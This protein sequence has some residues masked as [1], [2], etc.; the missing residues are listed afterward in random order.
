MEAEECVS[1]IVPIYNAEKYVRR[2]VE[3]ILQQTYEDLEILLVDDGSTDSGGAICDELAGKDERVRVW[4]VENGGVAS[5]RNKGLD[6]CR[7]AYVAFV[8]ADDYLEPDFVESL[9]GLLHRDHTVVAVCANNTAR[10]AVKMEECVMD[11]EKDFSYSKYMFGCFV[12]GKVYRREILKGLRFQEDVKVG[13]DTLFF[14]QVLARLSQLSYTDRI[15]YHYMSNE[16][17]AVHS[18]FSEGRYTEIISWQRLCEFFKGNQAR[19][20]DCMA[21][22]VERCHYMYSLMKR[23]GVKDDDRYD[24]LQGEVR[25]N[26]KYMWKYGHAWTKKLYTAFFALTP[27]IFCAIYCFLL[28]LHVDEVICGHRDCD[29]C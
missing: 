10:D 7:G 3:S 23:S 19:Y 25:K 14:G 20:A 2:C 24:F 5:A 22:Y 15:L 29:D 17:S 9:L 6:A 28:R 13:E 18:A 11:V 4:H 27:R 21:G 26:Y 1:V 8:D 16:G 12:W